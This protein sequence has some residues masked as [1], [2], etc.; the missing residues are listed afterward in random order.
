VVW[1]YGVVTVNPR[2]YYRITLTLITMEEHDI[3]A[4]IAWKYDTYVDGLDTDSD[5]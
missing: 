5:D 2:Y 3:D 4:L 1:S